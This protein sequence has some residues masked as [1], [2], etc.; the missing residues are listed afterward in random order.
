MSDGSLYVWDDNDPSAKGRVTTGKYDV[1]LFGRVGTVVV[2]VLPAGLTEG[3]PGEGVPF[4]VGLPLLSTT[5]QVTVEPGTKFAP[6]METG[7]PCPPLHG[8]AEQPES[9][10][11]M[12]IGTCT[13][14]PN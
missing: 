9:V 11:P 1:L 8:A 6:V 4:P 12:M 5:Y 2:I 14:Y 3:V 10:T 7:I 13:T